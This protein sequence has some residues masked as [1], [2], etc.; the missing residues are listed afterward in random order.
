MPLHTAGHARSHDGLRS[1]VPQI[2]LTIT[3]IRP[4]KSR[5]PR[6]DLFPLRDSEIVE[7]TVKA[8]GIELTVPAPP[9]WPL[10]RRL[11]SE[12]KISNDIGIPRENE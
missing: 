12:R 7:S 3:Q 9:S 5:K 4:K 11:A 6:L 10:T 2:H 8:L 1:S